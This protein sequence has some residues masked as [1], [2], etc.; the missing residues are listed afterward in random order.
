MV[1]SFVIYL[2]SNQKINKLKKRAKWCHCSI[3]RMR[4]PIYTKC[5]IHITARSN[6]GI[7]V[8]AIAYYPKSRF[9]HSPHW[10]YRC[11]ARLRIASVNWSIS[12]ISKLMFRFCIAAVSSVKLLGRVGAYRIEIGKD[13]IPLITFNVAID[14]NYK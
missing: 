4:K 6:K 7:H 8:F 3:N 9:I 5:V 11:E 2:T 12:I 10:T 13:T 1:H 14:N